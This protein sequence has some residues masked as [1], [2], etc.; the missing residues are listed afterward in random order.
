MQTGLYS[1]L[2]Y[3]SYVKSWCLTADEKPKFQM[4]NLSEIGRAELDKFF[5]KLFFVTERKHLA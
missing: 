1:S 2:E 5:G 3:N 4:L